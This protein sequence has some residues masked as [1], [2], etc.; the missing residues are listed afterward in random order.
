MTTLILAD[1]DNANL[2]AA[3]LNTI[4]AAQC[5]GGDI[6]VLVAGHE[7]ARVATAAAQIPGVSKILHADAAHF[8][9][10]TAENVAATVVA[11]HRA[12]SYSHVLA[13]ATTFGK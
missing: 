7:A 8:A 13:P 5:I 1:H 6:H 12:R 10:P 2:K 3:T 11:L 9:K 4:A